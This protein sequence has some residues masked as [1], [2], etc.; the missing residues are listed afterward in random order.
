MRILLATALLLIMLTGN[1]HAHFI[2]LLPSTAQDGSTSVDVYFGESAEPDDPDLLKMVEGTQVRSIGPNGSV[3]K[4]DLVRDEDRLWAK[5]ADPACLVEAT[6]DL[7]VIERGDKTFR[8]K[9]YAKSGPSQS[10]LWD[11]A[12]VP[13]PPALNLIPK[14][15][16]DKLQL[17]VIFEGKPAAKAEV[18][19]ISPKGD[20]VTGET[21][22]AGHIN[23]PFSE[24]GTYSIRARV[25]ESKP[26]ELKGKPFS[27]TRH[28]ATLAMNAKSEQPT[29]APKLEP[30]AQGVTSFGGA[31][32]DG[33][34]YIFGGHTGS[35]HSYSLLEQG[36]QLL[37]LDLKTGK[38]QELAEGP[39]SQG[40]ALIA[41]GDKLYRIGGFTAKNAKGEE[42]DLWSLDTVVA[43][44][45]KSN[46]WEQLPSL[47][48]PRSSFDAALLG[49]VIYVIGGWK[50]AGDAES[51]WHE[52]AWKLDL[53]KTPLK[54]EALPKPPFQRR[55]LAVAAH[56]GKI[57]AIGGM[58]K[59]GGPT[60]R[61]DVFD[62]KT[63]TWTQGPNLVI[64]GD[65]KKA[66]GIT[67]F[68]ASAFDVGGE[69]FVSTIKGTL[70]RLS[71]DGSKWE[72]VDNTPTARFFHRML[73]VDKD[74][75]L[76]VGGAN[77][78]VG[79]FEE[80]EILDVSKYRKS[81]K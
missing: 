56:D 26:G 17:S 53:S 29:E 13:Q 12:D 5:L 72:V 39:H 62:P 23:L 74:H 40:L 32:L 45:T 64:V 34:L 75:L 22:Q 21:D 16:G 19:S 58:Q 49:D 44:D 65:D 71:A 42:D 30:M 3:Q 43:F 68:G 48:Q 76:M 35:A 51:V 8:L 27:E 9:Y 67:G 50:M 80:V 60:T 79:K 31:M 59:E 57:Y 77:M 63:Q 61:T 28:Y 25:I 36:N 78:E 41:H 20:E 7:G 66:G 81:G 4:L 37:S 10:P 38:W 18:K 14:L 55:A 69:L 24:S 54:W 6:H 1:A 11:L 33:R 46:K 52:T 73:P 15:D 47:P 2:W 70:Q